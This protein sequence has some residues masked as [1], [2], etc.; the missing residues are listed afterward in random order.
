AQ[1]LFLGGI[2]NLLSGVTTVVHH[3][4]L[5]PELLQPQFPVRVLEHY[6]W[7]HSLYLDG[8]GAVRNS[9]LATREVDPWIIHVAEGVS[10][11][12][13]EEFDTL[14]ALGCIGAR[15]LLVHGVALDRAQRAR[16]VQAGAG[17]I[18]C[19]SSN[20]SLFGRTAEV[21]E[22]AA[23]GRVALGTDSR[24]SGARDLLEE[25]Q[26]ARRCC[27]LQEDELEQL[28][29]TAGARL[30]RLNDR[31]ALRAGYRADLLVLPSGVPL[32]QAQRS[33][34]RLVLIGG[35]P[36]Y[37]DEDYAAQLGLQAWSPIQL[38]GSAKL[39]AA[40]VV[41]TLTRSSVTEPGLAMD[42][43]DGRAA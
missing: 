31:G 14:D 18:W 25:L 35:V 17:L 12:A 6:G 39:L 28:V 38:D 4:P 3:D 29:T 10:R 16:L 40:G 9:Y 23:C 1:R 37:A 36:M 19:P 7:A 13:A 30:L 20:E 42:M 21:D 26:I 11:D 5:Y 33:D 34:I 2:K 22:L 15:T 8:A 24:L 27:L 41:A 43:S 32:G